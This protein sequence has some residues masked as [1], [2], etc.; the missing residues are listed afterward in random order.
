MSCIPYG[1]RVGNRGR[2]GFRR[3]FRWRDLAGGQNLFDGGND[4]AKKLV[5]TKK[6]T[7]RQPDLPFRISGRLRCN[8][9]SYGNDCIELE[10]VRNVIDKGQWFSCVDESDGGRKPAASTAASVMP[11]RQ[12]VAADKHLLGMSAASQVF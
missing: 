5:A 11:Y 9:E 8:S 1:Y 3:R 4:L 10:Q 7:T 12:E 6:V 2:D